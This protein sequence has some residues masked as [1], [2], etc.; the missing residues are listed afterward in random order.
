[1]IYK[2]LLKYRL[3]WVSHP[4]ISIKI[5]CVYYETCMGHTMYK[6]SQYGTHFLRGTG[7]GGPYLIID[8]FL[9]PG[10]PF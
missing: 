3:R 7:G 6:S 5:T 2:Y 4:F 1:M 9:F 10:F 8:C